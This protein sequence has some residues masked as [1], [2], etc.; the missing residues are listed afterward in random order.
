MSQLA[1]LESTM[2]TFASTHLNFELR[3]L[4]WPKITK[5]TILKTTITENKKREKRLYK[6]TDSFWTLFH[7]NNA[8]MLWT[9]H[10]FWEGAS[11]LWRK[12][13]LIFIESCSY[14]VN[15]IPLA[16]TMHARCAN[17]NYLWYARQR[18]MLRSPKGYATLAKWLTRHC[19]AYSSVH[20]DQCSH[21]AEYQL[22]WERCPSHTFNPNGLRVSAQP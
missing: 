16:A 19:E 9:R 8:N 3:A 2:S 6:F 22:Q 13:L 12:R 21:L 15:R 17:N 18:A 5:T 11:P 14:H 4:N 10:K 20:F 1:D 7:K